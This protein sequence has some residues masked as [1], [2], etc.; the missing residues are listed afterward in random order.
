[1]HDAQRRSGFV[2]VGTAELYY[3]EQGRGTPVVMLHGGGLD[4]HNWDGQFDVLARSY[5]AIRYD[6]R[7][8]GRSKTGAQGDFSYREDLYRLMRHLDVPKV[9]VMGLSL[10]GCVA[11]DFALTHP[12]MVLAL[13]PVSS[14]LTG[15]EYVGKSFLDWQKSVQEA[16]S[17]DGAVDAYM[18]CWMDGPSRAPEQVDPTLR[19]KVRQIAMG[20]FGGSAACMPFD[21]PA[22]PPAMGRLPEIGV[23]TLVV[24]GDIDMADIH[25]VADTVRDGVPEARKVVIRGAAHLANM[26]KPQEFNAAILEFLS[27]VSTVTSS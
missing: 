15:Y 25:E 22:Q 3:E 8:H 21:R 17:L 19:N 14:G 23:P 26:E 4:L 10:G 20:S 5:R 9:V 2:D 13:I 12:E 18:R 11:I 27:T 1:M 6:A 16:R 24:V 7:G